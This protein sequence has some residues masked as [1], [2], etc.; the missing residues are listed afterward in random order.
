MITETATK[1]KANKVLL[2]IEIKKKI[3]W[4]EGA[5]LCPL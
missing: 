3:Y 2:N 5:S 4:G 1:A